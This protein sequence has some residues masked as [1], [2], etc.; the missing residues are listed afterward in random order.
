VDLSDGS[1]PKYHFG[2]IEHAAGTALISTKTLQNIKLLTTI[3]IMSLDPSECVLHSN[4]TFLACF[5]SSKVLDL[6]S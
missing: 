2:P 6:T 5:G 3:V 4:S 1:P